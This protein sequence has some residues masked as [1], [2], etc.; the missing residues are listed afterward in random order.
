MSCFNEQ[1][2]QALQGIERNL[3]RIADMYKKTELI[4]LGI[5][6]PGRAFPEYKDLFEAQEK[7]LREIWTPRYERSP[8]KEPT[9]VPFVLSNSTDDIFRRFK[10]KYPSLANHVRAYYPAEEPDS[11]VIKLDIRSAATGSSVIIYNNETTEIKEAVNC[12]IFER[13]PE[14]E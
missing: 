2:L 12:K 13:R 1:C 3:E 11:I 8:E 14:H 6:D 10:D 9:C 5:L 4:K 7:E